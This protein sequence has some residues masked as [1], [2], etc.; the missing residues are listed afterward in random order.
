MTS[1][2]KMNILPCFNLADE[3]QVHDSKENRSQLSQ[4]DWQKE[5]TIKHLFL[6]MIMNLV[7]T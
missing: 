4:K 1:A 3:V 6:K 7:H 2:R 5:I